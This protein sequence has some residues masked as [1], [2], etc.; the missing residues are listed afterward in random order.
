[1]DLGVVSVVTC[2]GRRRTLVYSSMNRHAIIIL[3]LR[4]PRPF[5]RLARTLISWYGEQ[6]MAQCRTHDLTKGLS[7]VSTQIQAIFQWTLK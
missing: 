4:H 5:T 6:K 3:R 7:Y 2:S 1:M